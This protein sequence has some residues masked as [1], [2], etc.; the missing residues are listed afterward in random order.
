MKSTSCRPCFQRATLTLRLCPRGPTLF[1]WFGCWHPSSV[2]VAKW[3]RSL[4]SSA[5]RRASVNGGRSIRAG[6][7]C[8]TRRGYSAISDALC[9]SLPAARAGFQSSL[10]LIPDS[11]NRTGGPDSAGP[12]LTKPPPKA[13]LPTPDGLRPPIITSRH[14]AVSRPSPPPLPFRSSA[15]LSHRGGVFQQ[16]LP[17]ARHDV[18]LARELT[19]SPAS[20][21]AGTPNPAGARF[22]PGRSPCACPASFSASSPTFPGTP[23]SRTCRRPLSNPSCS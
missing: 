3:Q 2:L 17:F 9:E 19:P 6:S 7:E 15:S 22:P 12:H 1:N 21:S 18:P 8:L 5:D 16:Y 13:E 4:S 14:L 23:P 11:Q 20:R 10:L